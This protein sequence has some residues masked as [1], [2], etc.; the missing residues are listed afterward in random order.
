MPIA[1]GT[2]ASGKVLAVGDTGGEENHVLTQPELP[3]AL[4]G[5]TSTLRAWRTNLETLEGQW[6]APPAVKGTQQ[7]D[8]PT[9]TAQFSFD[10]D[11]GG[12]GHNNLSPFLCI[13]FIRKTQRRF[14]RLPA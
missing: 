7:T 8:P 5:I 1:P 6:L 11:G 2:L 3:A 14:W 10:N 13:N 12:Q 4:A 9:E